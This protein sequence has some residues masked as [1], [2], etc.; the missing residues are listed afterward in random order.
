MKECPICL[1]G[2]EY[3]KN[4]GECPKCKNF[5][6]MKTKSAN[7]TVNDDFADVFDNTFY[8]EKKPTPLI[9]QL[10]HLNL[11]IR[12]SKQVQREKQ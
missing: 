6:R 9:K 12:S 8:E 7:T 5:L 10:T 2:V 11:H 4:V 1:D 3:P